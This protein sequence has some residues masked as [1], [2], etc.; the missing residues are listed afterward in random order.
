MERQEEEGRGGGRRDQ[1]LA[2]I[3]RRS[4]FVAGLM[5]REE[6]PRK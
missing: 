6:K 3:L 5:P 4:T 1:K 2:G